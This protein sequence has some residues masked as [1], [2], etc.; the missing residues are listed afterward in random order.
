MKLPKTIGA[1]TDLGRKL[2]QD[3]IAK[4]REFDAEIAEMKSK[5]AEVE[6]AILDYCEKNKVGK[7]SGSEAT[8]TFNKN[9]I[10]T[11]KDW[12]AFYKHIRETGE[13][14]L[15]EKRPGKLAY[16]AR[17]EAGQRVPGCETFWKKSIS[18]SKFNGKA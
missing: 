3:R 16:K 6:A 13:F 11:V 5:E 7:V 15:L 8:A 2:E 4:Q 9:P 17:L 14:D 1:L 10:P 18:Y 12:D